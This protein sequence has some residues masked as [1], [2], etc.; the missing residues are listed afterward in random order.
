MCDEESETC[1]DKLGN[2][3][4]IIEVFPRVLVYDESDDS[5]EE[6]NQKDSNTE[7]EYKKN[8]QIST[9]LPGG[10]IKI[11]GSWNNWQS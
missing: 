1:F 7:K 9:N 3:N 8:I 5:E 10:D 4:N 2:K 6:N 11:V